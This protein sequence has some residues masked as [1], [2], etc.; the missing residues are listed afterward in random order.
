MRKPQFSYPINTMNILIK[1]FRRIGL[2]KYIYNLMSLFVHN[3]IN[4][5]CE[6]QKQSKQYLETL[7]HNSDA[8]CLIPM[9][10][11][12]EQIY[13]LQVI[14][15][16]Y[17]AA[18]YIDSCV[19]SILHQPTAYKI[20]V[21]V[22]ND[23]ST[24]ATGTILRKYEEDPRVNIVTQENQGFSGARNSGLNQI[25]AR[26]ISFLDSDDE[27][28]GEVDKLIRLADENE[29]D[30]VEGSYV[31]FNSKGDK[32]TVKHLDAILS[33]TSNLYGYPWGKL[34]KST[35]FEHICFPKDYWFED[36]IM[37]F[38]V[39]PLCHKIVTSS[40]LFYHYRVNPRGI[41]ATFAKKLKVIDSYWITE[42]L[43]KDRD[44]LGM[45]NEKFADVMLEQIKM[46]YR[47]IETMNC[48][49]VNRAVFVLT[50]NLWN[51]Y[52]ANNS[53]PSPL[54]KILEKGDYAAYKLYCCLC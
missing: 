14:I 30:I 32:R 3:K 17:N 49:D 50:A 5:D 37:A 18:K 4:V 20:L 23:G 27:W 8:S 15:P 36:T 47:R 31:T 25:R 11:K 34:F 46:N 45:T 12:L 1:L 54:A 40:M 51:K 43:L 39:Y 16:A 41:T 6:A 21:T 22:I 10:H 53:S 13:D 28:L 35:L 7:S 42:R 26:Y 44:I 33:D 19:D 2:G 52:F 48:N 29:A 24:D 9:R 38:I